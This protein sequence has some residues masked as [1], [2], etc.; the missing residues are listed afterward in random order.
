M[1]TILIFILEC[2]SKVYEALKSPNI[3]I[4]IL[5]LISLGAI[6]ALWLRCKSLESDKNAY[7]TSCSAMLDSVY[8]YKVSDSLNAIQVGELLLTAK[9]YKRY[10]AE[11][12]ALI[13]QLVA[14]KVTS[15][16]NLKSITRDTVFTELHDTVIAI[17]DTVKHF[18]Y[19]SKW[20]DVNGFVL[21]NS[22]QVNIQ[23]REELIITESTQRKKFWFIKLPPKLF[24]YKSRKLDVVSKNPNTTIAGVEWVNIR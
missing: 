2:F 11:D 13:K 21:G 5:I 20:T 1:S 17:K 7:W 24:G 9:E 12:A 4:L 14:D 23:N 10:R 22:I 19:T 8:K 3:R 18:S 6:S 16:T 15:V